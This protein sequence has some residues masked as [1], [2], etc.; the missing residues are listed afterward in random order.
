MKT[1][2]KKNKHNKDGP[3]EKGDM[4]NMPNTP[5]NINDEGKPIK[6]AFVAW[7]EHKS[8]EIIDNKNIQIIEGRTKNG[9]YVAYP[10]EAV[11]E[12]IITST[13]E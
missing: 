2:F 5:E 10:K 13:D 1:I 6:K 9:G 12:E 8:S 7:P 11:R 3:V 4:L